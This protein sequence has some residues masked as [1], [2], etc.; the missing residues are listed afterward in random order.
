[1][2]L[3]HDAA[4]PGGIQPLD[5]PCRLNARFFQTLQLQFIMQTS[6]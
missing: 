5:P 6:C 3:E 2:Q 4:V 1:M